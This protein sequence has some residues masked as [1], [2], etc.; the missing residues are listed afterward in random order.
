MDLVIP[1]GQIHFDHNGVGSQSA[2]NRQY[3]YGTIATWSCID[4]YSLIWL[5]TRSSTCGSHGIWIVS[6]DITPRCGN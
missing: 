6:G 4:G 5:T 1:N 2:P 3:P